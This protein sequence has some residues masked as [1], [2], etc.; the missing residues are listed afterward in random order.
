MT[1]S[2]DDSPLAVRAFE[3]ALRVARLAWRLPEYPPLRN[4]AGV[5]LLTAA[6]GPVMRPRRA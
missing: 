2:A 3:E 4:A 6:I 5:P 1:P